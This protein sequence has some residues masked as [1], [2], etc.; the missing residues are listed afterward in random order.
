MPHLA[1]VV[2]G[3]AV[4]PTA[5]DESGAQPGPER[6]EHDVPESSGRPEHPLRQCACLRVVLDRHRDLE[7]VTEQVLE[8]DRVPAG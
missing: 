4:Q 3:A 6:E 7:A 1:G 8:G 2:A 5:E